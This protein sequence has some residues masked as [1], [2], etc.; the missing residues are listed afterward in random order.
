MTSRYEKLS[1]YFNGS[2]VFVIDSQQTLGGLRRHDFHDD[3]IAG[4]KEV[5]LKDMGKIGQCMTKTPHN[6]TQAM[7]MFLG[8]Y[9]IRSV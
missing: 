5:I 7:Y 2:G 3:I 9:C 6:K 4:T 8:M 1:S